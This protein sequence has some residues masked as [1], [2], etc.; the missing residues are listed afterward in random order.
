MQGNGQRRNRYLKII[1]TGK[2]WKHSK[3]LIEQ[4]MQYRLRGKTKLGHF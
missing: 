4:L 2:T 1:G 3:N